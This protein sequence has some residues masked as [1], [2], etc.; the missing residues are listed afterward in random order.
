M[1]GR[2]QKIS[3]KG[4]EYGWSSTVFCLIESFWGEDLFEVAAK[5]EKEKAI[6]VITEQILKLNPNAD[7]KK[8]MKFIKG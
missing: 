8:I 3:R 2:Q 4:E 5:I 1:C 7:M 6:Q